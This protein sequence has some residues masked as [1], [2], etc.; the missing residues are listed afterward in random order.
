MDFRNCKECGRV[1]QSN[2]F[3]KIC[4]RCQMDDEVNYAKVKEY[5]YDHPGADISEVS[6][7]TE[8]SKDK[9]LHYLRDGRLEIIGGDSMILDCERCG[10]GISTGRF[11]RDCAKELERGLKSGFGQPEKEKSKENNKERMFIAEMRNKK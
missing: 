2:G 9:I 10:T 3:G 11:C 4:P 8:V 5:V 6:D 1:F 7:K